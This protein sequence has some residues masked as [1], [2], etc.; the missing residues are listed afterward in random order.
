M[1][2]LLTVIPL[3][4]LLCFT[5]SCQKG[6]EIA[7]KPVVDVEAEKAKVKTALD[8]WIRAFE[9]ED[10]ELL[11]KVV[12]H[13]PD[14]VAIGTDTGEY[15]IGWEAFKESQQRWFDTTETAE[16][17]VRK[18]RIKVHKSGEVA[19]FSQF[20]DWKVKAKEEEFTF[21]GARMTGVLEKQN[22]DWVI[23]Q[24]HGSAPLATTVEY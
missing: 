22:D 7:E 18:Q 4:F 17:S 5:F 23:V 1:K 11:S 6:E 10:M 13:E 24:L 15:F 20:L 16:I 2:K 21:E 19:W 3:V 9:T 14:I 8:G 12:S